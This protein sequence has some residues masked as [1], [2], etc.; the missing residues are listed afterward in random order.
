MITW[1]LEA[2]LRNVFAPGMLDTS[3]S[4][5]KIPA[6]VNQIDIF[7][8]SKV[9]GPSTDSYSMLNINHF[10]TKNY[11]GPYQHSFFYSD[12]KITDQ[13]LYI[14]SDF[15]SMILGTNY[16]RIFLV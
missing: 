5:L 13:T 16:G 1:S 7:G 3:K 8:A 15:P 10:I 14:A 11:F 2:L 4:K 12:E 9:S 6:H